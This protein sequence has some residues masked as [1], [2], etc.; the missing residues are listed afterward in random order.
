LEQLQQND[1]S[2]DNAIASHQHN[3]VIF[4]DKRSWLLPII[5]VSCV[6]LLTKTRAILSCVSFS[7]FVP[8]V[9]SSPSLT[10]IIDHG[11]CQ[12]LCRC[13]W[14]P[15]VSPYQ[16]QVFCQEGRSQDQSLTGALH[17]CCS[18]L[19]LSEQKS[20]EQ[21]T[22]V[23]KLARAKRQASMVKHTEA[24]FR[25]KDNAMTI[26]GLLPDQPTLLSFAQGAVT[27]HLFW[28]L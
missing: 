3:A 9:V 22:T 24:F 5:T 28:T 26:Q 6:S 7:F 11:P 19:D 13:P 23:A 15:Q 16:G 12:L 4:L 27:S 1:S 8:F 14:W 18:K 21:Q 2:V 10:S 20:K 17:K 25:Y